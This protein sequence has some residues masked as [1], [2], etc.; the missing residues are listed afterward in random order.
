MLYLKGREDYP[1]SLILM[2]SAISNPDTGG[3]KT[4][5]DITL[6]LLRRG[7]ST[8]L[9][10]AHLKLPPEPSLLLA[11]VRHGVSVLVRVFFKG[12]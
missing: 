12:P 6:T 10:G 11:T 9:P 3:W 8:V 7:G 1:G 2:V 4:V 5:L